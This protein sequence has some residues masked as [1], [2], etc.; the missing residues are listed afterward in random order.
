MRTPFSEGLAGG[1]SS[2]DV[3]DAGEEGDSSS[4]A[5]LPGSS[6][7]AV[8]IANTAT[9]TPTLMQPLTVMP[10]PLATVTDCL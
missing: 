6:P 1:D 9:T 7:H 8:P 4:E 3:D 10:P 5:R 2:G